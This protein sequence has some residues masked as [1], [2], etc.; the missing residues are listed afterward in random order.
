MG[1]NKSVNWKQS[2]FVAIELGKAN[3]ENWMQIRLRREKK[4]NLNKEKC[5]L[6]WNYGALLKLVYP[7]LFDHT[8]DNI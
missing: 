1:T 4:D 3:Q 8:V 6:F 5:G 7:I 2:A